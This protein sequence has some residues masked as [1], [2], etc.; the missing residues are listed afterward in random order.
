MMKK[1]FYIMMV[2]VFWGL[3]GCQKAEYSLFD[4]VARVQMSGDKE[5]LTDFYYIDK[6]VGR[7]TAYLTVSV[8]GG[9]E[10][11]ERK[12]ELRQISEYDVEYKYDAKGNLID[13]VVTEKPNKAVP[14]V[15]YVGMDD[16][17]MRPLLV[18]QANAVYARI[19]V[20]LLR[21]TSLQTNEYRLCLELT[22]SSDFRLGESNQLSRTIIFADKLS[23]PSWWDSYVT[24][25]NFGVYSTR[26]HEFM[27][28]VLDV[29]LGDEWYARLKVDFGEMTFTRNKLKSALNAYNA[30][31][32][33][34]AA[35]LAPMREKQDD[36]NSALIVFP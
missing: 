1:V 18:V 20:I 9:P 34:I 23:Q 32:E 15:H 29:V 21:D 27:I 14:G 5:I 28:E 7:D 8:I 11:R 12:L 6:S 16:E 3:S 36:P 35:G 30:D 31:P 4:D 25:S 33:N 10:N 22:E 13:S 24:K 19:P 26:K 2:S 17:E